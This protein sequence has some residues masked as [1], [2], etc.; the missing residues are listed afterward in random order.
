MIYPFMIKIFDSVSLTGNME[1]IENSTGLKKP[2]M[3][4]M[5][6]FNAKIL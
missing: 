4:S 1:L 2:E 3:K 5:I 6:E